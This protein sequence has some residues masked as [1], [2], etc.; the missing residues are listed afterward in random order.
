MN[1]KKNTEN[2]L[3]EW[4]WNETTRCF[5]KAAVYVLY[6][7]LNLVFKMVFGIFLAALVCLKSCK[8]CLDTSSSVFKEYSD[9][10]Q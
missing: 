8:K 6:L 9:L 4:L 2:A 5:T 10:R 7:E 3:I 1:V